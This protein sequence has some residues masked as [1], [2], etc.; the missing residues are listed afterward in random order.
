MDPYHIALFV[1]MVT[2]AV[3][4]SVTAM[5]KLAAA[6]RIQ[7]RTVGEA[8]EW[9]NMMASAAKVFPVCLVSFTTTGFYMLSFTGGAHLSAGYVDAGLLGVILLLASGTYLGIKGAGLKRILEGAVARDPDAA[10]TRIMPPVAVRL[11]PVINT[12]IAIGVAFVMVAKPA[13][14]PVAL[15][16]VALGGLIAAVGAA[17][18]RAPRPAGV[19]RT[20]AR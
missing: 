5:V 4:G 9:H 6:R 3:A 1:H 14:I 2:L 17:R 8:L 11:L 15:G 19:T 20:A 13:S 7:A 16:I 18:Q 10:P 12:G